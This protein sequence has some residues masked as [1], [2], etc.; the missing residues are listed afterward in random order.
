MTTRVR[1]QSTC[2]ENKIVKILISDQDFYDSQTE[3][4][5]LRNGEARDFEVSD[6]RAIQVF[7][8]RVHPLP[9]WR[10][11]SWKHNP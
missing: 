2:G 1:V 10:P 3:S 8:E 7:E 11:G 9:H 4:T 6:T 5:S